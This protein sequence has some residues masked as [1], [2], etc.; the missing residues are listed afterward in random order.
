MN[1]DCQIRGKSDIHEALST[2]CEVEY[3]EGD[4]KVFCDNCKKNTDTVL[5]TAISAL[6]DMLILS[7]KRFDLDYTTFETVKLNSRC[8][9]GQSLNMKRYTLE[10]VEAMEK[11]NDDVA[12]SA[13]SYIDPL[14]V[15]PDDDYEY[16]LAGVLV[17]HGVAQGGHYYSFIRDRTET[18]DGSD[19]WFRFDDEDVTPFDPSNIETECFGGKIKKETK[20]PN[21]QVNAVE[22]E[23]LANALMLFYEKVKPTKMSD[24]EEKNDAMEV[25]K[26]NT[27]QMEMVTGTTE[28]K[29]DVNKSNTLYRSHSFLF[30]KDFQLFMQQMVTLVLDNLTSHNGEEKGKDEN[31]SLVHLNV[32]TAA[33]R[34]FFDILSHNIEKGDLNWW[35]NHIRKAFSIFPEF[36]KEF[37][38][39][40]ASRTHLHAMNWMQTFAADCPEM[41]VRGA[42]MSLFADAVEGAI[43]SHDVLIQHLRTWTQDRLEEVKN[44][45]STLRETNRLEMLIMFGKDGGSST[46]GDILQFV[47]RLLQY[48]P[49]IWRYTP[50]LCIFV[51]KIATIPSKNGGDFLRNALRA[52][53]VPAILIA[54]ILRREKLDYLV[55]GA[56]PAAAIPVDVV[57]QTTR[58]ESSPTSHLP[59]LTNNVN[60]NA[61][62]NMTGPAS[63]RPSPTDQAK[64]FE[65]IAA[66]LGIQG[67]I[68]AQLLTET[69]TMDNTSPVFTLSSSLAQMLSQIFDHFASQPSSMSMKDAFKY[70][71]ICTGGMHTDLPQ[72]RMANMMNQYGSDSTNIS[73]DG[74]LNYY[75][76]LAQSH[77]QDVSLLLHLQLLFASCISLIFMISFHRFTP[78]YSLLDT[79]PISLQV[80]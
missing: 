37:T 33:V 54:S 14:A 79:D 16:K 69:G 4:N 8:E 76:D 11:A 15:L 60:M 67:A 5:R 65:T 1:I 74:F 68:P 43:G 27:V 35:C 36:S 58:V 62:L 38:A 44:W 25:D 2:M 73:R 71:K 49:R 48:S 56:F 28:F 21:G 20:W 29:A 46:V 9:F 50:E 78:I 66:L 42:A 40:L 7:L 41:D 30:D 3:M 59:L 39:E 75:R 77:E 22:T 61:T 80:T 63:G 70:F 13:D 26:E 23:Q 6:P 24:A 57:E 12:S 17:H 34:Y 64:L 10:G 53:Q 52:S 31:M 51:S 47:V 55:V 45:H 18:S 19:Q 32:L 72:D